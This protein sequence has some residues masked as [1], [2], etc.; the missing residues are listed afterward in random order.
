MSYGIF[1]YCSYFMMLFIKWNSLS[2]WNFIFHFFDFSEQLHLWSRNRQH[3]LKD[4]I[5]HISEPPSGIC[6]RFQDLK[7]NPR[8]LLSF[9]KEFMVCITNFSTNNERSFHKII[10]YFMDS[11]FMVLI[12]RLLCAAI[13]LEIIK[14]VFLSKD[15]RWKASRE[16][17]EQ[18]LNATHFGVGLK[19][20]FWRN[21][22]QQMIPEKSNQT[23]ASG[24]RTEISR[25]FHPR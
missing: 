4:K 24:P 11:D 22:W 9:L 1:K 14:K 2:I 12:C 17:Q 15:S 5:G 19:G 21:V 6:G 3:R 16:F 10:L 7:A 13:C 23:V 8:N 20:N 25:Y 18:L